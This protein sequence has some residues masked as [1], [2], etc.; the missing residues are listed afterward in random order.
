[1]L[2]LMAAA[3]GPWPPETATEQTCVDIDMCGH[4]G[5]DCGAGD[6]A[7]TS[8]D[9]LALTCAEL[10]MVSASNQGSGVPLR[11]ATRRGVFA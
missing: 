9:S 5:R 11:C 2:Q 8:F 3:V 7:R 10:W 1:M 6:A 4:R